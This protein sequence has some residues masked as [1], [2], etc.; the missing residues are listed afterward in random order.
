MQVAK[1]WVSKNLL[2]WEKTHCFPWDSCK[3][4]NLLLRIAIMYI[5]GKNKF[6]ILDKSA[7]K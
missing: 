3:E 4:S 5:N 6:H 1:K 7:E 2:L